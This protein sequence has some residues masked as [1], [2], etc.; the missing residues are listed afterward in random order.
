[1]SDNTSI[2]F[3][4]FQGYRVLFF[5]QFTTMLIC[6]NS[7]FIC[8]QGDRVLLFSQFTMMLDVI[9]VFFQQKDYKYLRLDGQTPV[10]DRLVIA[11]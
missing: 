11:V 2:E 8:F 9:E 6:H 1:M 10:P 4:Y 3:M 5:S 7:E